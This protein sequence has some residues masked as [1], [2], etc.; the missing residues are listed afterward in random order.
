ML[1]KADLPVIDY[2]ARG[3]FPGGEFCI[4]RELPSSVECRQYFFESVYGD[5]DLCKE[6]LSLLC[7]LIRSM[8]KEGIFHPDFHLGNILYSR[9]KHALFLPDPYGLKHSPS[10][11]DFDLRI[12]HPFLELCNFVPREEILSQLCRASLAADLPEAELLLENA[13]YAFRRRRAGVYA[14]LKKRILSG[15]S[16]YATTVELPGGG[17]CSFRHTFWYSPP[18][19]LCIHPEW[20]KREY[21]TAEET[22]KIWVDSFLAVPLPDGKDVPLARR[23]LPSGKSVLYYAEKQGR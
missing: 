21:A 1:K 16:K 3:K 2:I 19:R 9:E 10:R 11:K 23:I 5:P 8:K 4:S 18:E 20:E 22:E 13:L 6:F 7:N 17:V 14:K 15:K 12:C